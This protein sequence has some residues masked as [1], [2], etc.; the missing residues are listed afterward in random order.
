MHGEMA[1]VMAR[2]KGKSTDKDEN[3]ISL[4]E[5]RRNADPEDKSSGSAPGREDAVAGELIWLHCPTCHTL[6]YTEL[7][8]SGGRVHNTCGTRVEEVAVPLD[9]RAEYTIAGINLDR[10]S[11]LE[12]LLEGQRRRYEE[13]RERLTLA[14]GHDLEPYPLGDEEISNLPVAELD[15]LGLLVSRFFHQ[16]EKLFSSSS[17]AP[18]EEEEGGGSEPSDD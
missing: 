14:A 12:N 17:G 13:Y 10:L 8:M 2:D 7:H 6:E 4:D 5:R 18:P 16:P 15:P 3:V 9:L 1:T 11:I